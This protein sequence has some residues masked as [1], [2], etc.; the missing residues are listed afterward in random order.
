MYKL[1]LCIYMNFLIDPN[2]ELFDK[3]NP[4]IFRLL[5]PPIKHVGLPLWIFVELISTPSF[6]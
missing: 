1:G 3:T 6:I 4:F 5:A 2:D